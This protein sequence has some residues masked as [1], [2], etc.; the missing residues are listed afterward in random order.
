MKAETLALKSATVDFVASFF[1]LE[2][3]GHAFV[4]L[5][6]CES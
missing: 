6:G 3:N 5:S 2:A 1:V 4:S